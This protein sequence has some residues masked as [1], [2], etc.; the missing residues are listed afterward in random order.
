[1]RGILLPLAA[2]AVGALGASPLPP[3][4]WSALPHGTVTPTGWLAR[5]LRLQADSL[6]GT[7]FEDYWEPVNNSQ[8]LGGTST[9]EGEAMWR[10]ARRPP[11]ATYLYNYACVPDWV[12]IFPYVFQ[13]FVPQAIQLNDSAQLATSERWINAILARASPNG[14]LGPLENL[15]GGMLYWPRWPI[16][17]TFLA[18]H[19]YGVVLNGTG[20]A[21]VLDASLAW[22][23]IAYTNLTTN[24]PLDNS[25]SGFRWQDFIFVAQALMDYK[26]TP[27]SAIPLLQ[28]LSAVVY[29]QGTRNID[30]ERNWYT[31]QDFPKEGVPSW[32]ILPHGVNNGGLKSG[33][34]VRGRLAPC[35]PPPSTSHG[36]QIGRRRVARRPQ[37]RGQHVLVHAR[38]PLRRVPRG[39]ERHLPGAFANWKGGGVG[40]QLYPPGC[41]A[42][43]QADE[44]LAGAMPSRGSETC[45]V[46]E[47]MYSYSISE[48]EGEKL[49]YPRS[50]PPPPL[51]TSSPPAP[52]SQSTSSRAT[53]S[54]RTA[55][56]AS[57][58]TR[59]PAR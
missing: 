6:S 53:P 59:C 13:G 35:M 44:C 51:A 22:C 57:R 58:T 28:N 42:S 15:P 27:P 1:M 29:A 38:R 30:W 26:Y 25:W 8:W 49:M 33:A 24:F 41:P 40:Y 5:E 7:F 32:N 23:A 31:E 9:Q 48:L 52:L 21:R 50:A 11:A 36:H 4:A 39:A 37:P 14:W 45:L 2:L 16:V 12:E 54:L 18:W 19:E 17:L 46:V 34:G 47:L 20:D 3:L 56:S 43:P 10:V 55:R